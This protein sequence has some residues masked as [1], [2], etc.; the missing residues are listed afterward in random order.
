MV[1]WLSVCA[2]STKSNHCSPTCTCTCKCTCIVH[3]HTCTYKYLHIHLH[4]HLLVE[5]YSQNNSIYQNLYF[6]KLKLTCSAL[7]NIAWKH[8][9]KDCE[10]AHVLVSY[11]TS[12]TLF[13]VQYVPSGMVIGPICY[14]CIVIM[15]SVSIEH[16]FSCSCIN[17]KNVFFLY[18]FMVTNVR[19]YLYMYWRQRRLPY[20]VNPCKFWEGYNK[21]LFV[22]Y[23]PSDFG[24]FVF[25]LV[26]VWWNKRGRSF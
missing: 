24:H 14:E 18:S 16:D 6:E 26:S 1:G 8:E 9:N 10:H 17:Q 20:N 21:F 7:R 15:S 22:F 3:V 5:I 23:H 19:V 4:V 2:V 13:H 25:K 11:Q 12:N